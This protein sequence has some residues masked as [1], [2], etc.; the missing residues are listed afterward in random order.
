MANLKKQTKR[1]HQSL[2]GNPGQ[3]IPADTIYMNIRQEF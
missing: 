2:S 1:I 3:I